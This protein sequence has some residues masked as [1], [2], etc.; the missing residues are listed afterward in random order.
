MLILKLPRVTLG[1]V[2]ER[3][4]F[5]RPG[6]ACSPQP[7]TTGLPAFASATVQM[8]EVQV[9]GV[10]ACAAGARASRAAA[11]HAGRA[12][13]LTRGGGA[14]R[15]MMRSIMS[16]SDE[17]MA[18]RQS[19]GRVSGKLHFQAGTRAFRRL[20]TIFWRISEIV[21]NFKLR[22]DRRL[23]HPALRTAI[24][25]CIRSDRSAI[26]GRYAD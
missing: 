25:S 21:G 22:H 7:S 13:S 17:L 2:L 26:F 1:L 20:Y 6:V 15:V 24:D 3:I 19:V 11:R 14:R 5:M 16:S 10:C 4:S 23:V 9:G 12:V 8:L 18:C